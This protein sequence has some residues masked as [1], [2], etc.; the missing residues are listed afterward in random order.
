M[1][2]TR[3][4]KTLELESL[5]S[6]FEKSV[7]A[8]C[9][10]YRGMTVAQMT[11]LRSDLRKAGSVGRVVK[12]TLARLSVERTATEKKQG[13]KERFIQTLEGPSF[14]VFSFED[15]IAPTKVLAE[16]AKK[17]EKFRV[18]GCWLDGAFVD[19]AGVTELSKMPGR[20]ETLSMLLGLI[21]APAT[22]LARVLNESGSQV[23]RVV[24]A[25]RKKL[26]AGV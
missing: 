5:S 10:D 23:A 11:K 6:N 24:D 26:E 18:K 16:F 9:A 2:M 25:Q 17:N 19:P 14:V 20:L 22:R 15:P 1:V 8:V 4:D 12:N 7:V 21:S 13:E 3:S